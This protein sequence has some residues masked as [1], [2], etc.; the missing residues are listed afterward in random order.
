MGHHHAKVGLSVADFFCGA[1]GFSEGFAAAGFEIV[2]GIDIG[3]DAVETFHANHRSAT[4]E[5]GDLT[6]LD[7]AALRKRVRGADVI[8]GG[9]C[10]QG[11]STG[12]RGR[13]ADWSE[14]NKLWKR[15]L[16]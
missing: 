12:G 13:K 2:Y 16:L 1:G 15:M 7:R 4:H 9:P 6:E 5:L 8:V 10:C 14:R 3:A 11:F